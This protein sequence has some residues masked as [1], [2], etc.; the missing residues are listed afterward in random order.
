MRYFVTGATGFIGGHVARQLREGGHEV[1]A[2]VR[3][4]SHAQSLERIGVRLFRGDVTDRGSLRAPMEGTDGIFHIAA[5]YKIGAKD[6]SPAEPINLGGTR[7]VLETMRELG[8]RKGVY[9]STLGVF[10]DTHGQVA[11]ESYEH[12]G[13]F[14]SEYERT[15]AKAHYEVALPMMKAGL[16]LVIVMPGGVYGVGDTSFAH[17]LM[18]QYLRGKLRAIPRETALCFAR[19]EDTA[20]GHLLAMERGVP[21]QSYII[22]GEGSTLVA[23]FDL[24][25]RTTG[26]PA[27]KMHPPAGLVRF[28]AAVSGSEMLKGATATYL[29]TNAKARRELGFEPRSIAEGLPEV[30][31]YEQAKLGVPAAVH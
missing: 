17:D 14:I 2:L 28:L 10:S 23:L 19:V 13:K 11:D 30:L 7:N 18:V 24:A 12:H 15:K 5:W 20:R 22:A 31:R 26:V 4:P 9:T 27:P 8:I 29:G 25:S 6:R 21:G 1:H 16:P 3:D